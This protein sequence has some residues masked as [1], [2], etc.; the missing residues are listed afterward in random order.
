MKKYLQCCIYQANKWKITIF[1]VF[2]FSR[3][4]FITPIKVKMLTIVGILIFIIMINFMLSRVWHGNFFITS[5]QSCKKTLSFIT[6]YDYDDYYRQ[7][8]QYYEYSYY[9]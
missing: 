3:V 4:I 9:D 7:P 5:G 6:G 2:K 1:L 8:N